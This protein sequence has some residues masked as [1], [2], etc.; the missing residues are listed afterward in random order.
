MFRV[1]WNTSLGCWVAVSEISRGRGK[2]SSAKALAPALLFAAL[3]AGAQAQT[4]VVDGNG[5]GGCMVGVGSCGLPT[6][7]AL[8]TNFYTQGG[9]GSG[10]GAGLGGVFF[11][12]SGSSLH[13]NNVTFER[14]TVKGGEGGSTPDVNVSGA[15]LTLIEKSADVT[16][17]TAFQIKPTIVDTAGTLTISGVTL[18]SAN[19]LLKAGSLVS[20]GGATG[21]IDTLSGTDVTFVQPV[22][23]DASA[24]KS[25]A[26]A[27]A[28][29]GSNTITSAS[30]SGMAP[31]DV[32][33]G[34]TVVGAGIPDGTTITQV[35]RDGS[36]A[37]TS[38]TLSNNVTSAVNGAI[39]L[40]D[41]TSFQASQFQTTANANEIKL[42]AT[43]LGLAV[44]M[45]LTGDGVPAN[46]Q[47][48]AIN[49]DVVT[50]SNP[51]TGL[52]F[53]GSL[54]IGTV[55]QNQIQLGMMDSRFTVGSAITG[56][57]IPA[58]TTITAIDSQTGKITLSNNLT[59]IP[60]EIST[61]SILAQAGAT[62][63]LK[64]A[65]GLQ[66]G[67]KL[68]GAGIPDGTT[69]LSISG[70]TVTLSATPTGSVSGFL[71]SSA[72]STG[73]SLNNIAAT[74]ATGGNGNR[75]N[76]ATNGIVWIRDGEGSSGTNGGNAGSGTNGAGGRGGNGGNGSSGAPFNYGLTFAVLN[77]TKTAVADTAAA[78]GA[79]A[80]FPPNAVLSAAHVIAAGVAYV[81][82]GVAIAN[83]V[84]WGVEL[85]NGT[86]GR[87][88]DGGAGGNGGKGSTFYGGGAGGNGGVGGNGALSG[89][90][91]GAGGD[92]G[93]GGNGGFGAGGG[94]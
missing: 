65:A 42:A 1:V 24:I 82:L 63:Q 52:S 21:T 85:S 5:H 34:M 28:A 36:N 73:G 80:T 6:S 66:V 8:F 74:G 35:T 27:T 38:I 13:L 69:I 40:V 94:S 92:G 39:K 32:A 59:A 51:I 54:P 87:G 48:T 18:G 79:L 61:K 33:T 15:S 55:G 4:T 71:A 12:N 67:M 83:L 41:V 31:S 88:G 81:D 2:S 46:T 60:G 64:S 10:G 3:G 37:V 56:N 47:V 84:T 86:A 19:P 91:G 9:A 90:D 58:G 22:T 43:G 14:N 62:L 7:D 93:S 68:E 25:V 16:S 76:S 75:G 50:L 17:V 30:F 11:V 23:V 78:A 26:G 57:G 89:T 45:T 49:G 77:A 53:A 44:G 72:Y 29:N 70:N 20:L